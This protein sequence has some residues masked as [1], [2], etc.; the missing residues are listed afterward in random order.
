MNGGVGKRIVPQA[1]HPSRP[2][3]GAVVKGLRTRWRSLHLVLLSVGASCPD[4]SPD[5]GVAANRDSLSVS[6]AV[7][8][9][10]NRCQSSL[11]LTRPKKAGPAFLTVA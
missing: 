3:K 2:L 7:S 9:A 11:T 8:L 6:P 10:N 1:E 4:V 5:Q